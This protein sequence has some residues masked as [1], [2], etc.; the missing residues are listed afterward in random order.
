[1]IKS[2]LSFCLLLFLSAAVMAQN[3]Q[4]TGHVTEKGNN[5]PVIAASVSV[6][7]TRGGTQTDLNG[8]FKISIPDN[9]SVV[10]VITS[11]G[12]TSREITINAKETTVN[13]E[14]ESNSQ[15]LNEVVAIGYQTVKRRDLTGSVSSVTAKDLRDNPTLSA[16]EG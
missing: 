5:L 8:A 14:L 15:Q 6:K 10:L 2:L 1:M 13:V 9:F 4:V 3:R 12:Y 11:V 16:A 7:G